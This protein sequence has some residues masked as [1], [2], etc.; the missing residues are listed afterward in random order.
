[1][2]NSIFAIKLFP[3]WG[4]SFV[5]EVFFLLACDETFSWL[6]LPTKE[7]NLYVPK[8]TLFDCKFQCCFANALRE[9]RD[10]KGKFRSFDFRNSNVNHI[11]STLVCLESWVQVLAHEA[12]KCWDRS[13]ET[14]LE[15]FVGNH[16]AGE[17][18]Y[19][20]HHWRLVHH[21]QTVLWLGA[22]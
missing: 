21:P 8:R 16:S 19:R 3:N 12:W 10:V 6:I 15:S 13:A 5:E 17:I 2:T 20:L 14:L 9:C 7:L 4:I 1:M 18:E 11:L 22:I